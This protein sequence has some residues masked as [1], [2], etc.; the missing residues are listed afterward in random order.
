[1]THKEVTELMN[2]EGLTGFDL[3]GLARG[4]G[5]GELSCSDFCFFQQGC[6]GKFDL[7]DLGR[8]Q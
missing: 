1:M 2:G 4:K 5:S 3:N 8:G 6:G 7:K